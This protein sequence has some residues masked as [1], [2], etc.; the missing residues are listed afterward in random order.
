MKL[1][2][3]ILLMELQ[4]ANDGK[5]LKEQFKLTSESFKPVNLIKDTFHELTQGPDFKKDLVG[6]VMGIATGYLSKKVAIGN[7]HNPLK[8]IM[9]V[10]VQLAIT[11]VVSKNSEK[12]KSGLTKLIHKF[13]NQKESTEEM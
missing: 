9:G 12:I 10:L 6:S 3:S 7:S 13:T 4:Q 1:K 11:S 8:Q 5:L 2:E